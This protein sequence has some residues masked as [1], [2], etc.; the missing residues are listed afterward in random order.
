MGVYQIEYLK[1]EVNILF[2]PEKIDY[3]KCLTENWN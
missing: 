1:F 2:Y 3:E